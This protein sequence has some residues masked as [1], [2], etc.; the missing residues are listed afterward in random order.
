LH[1]GIGRNISVL[2]TE[3]LLQRLDEIGETLGRKG[4]ALLL[5][6]VGSV[7]VELERMDEYSDLDFFVIVE[8]GQ[9]D[10]YI[11]RLDWLEETYPLAYAFKNSDVGCKILFEDGIYGEYAIFEERELTDA[12]YTEGRVVWK[13]PLYSNTA[14]AKPR[15]ALPSQKCDALDFPLNEALT[16]LYVGLGRYARGERLSAA[17]FIQGHAIDRILSV[18]HLLEPEVVYYPDPFGNE[19]RLEK[20]YPGFAEK[21]GGMLQGYDR[22]P[23]SALC[24]LEFIE[25]V[26]PANPRLSTEI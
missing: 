24:I 1:S 17:R 2:R 6:G 23:E 7:G 18:L 4:G 25:A 5:L 13:D 8:A 20:R 14:I 22:V 15:R 21:L 9:K 16:N 3:L 11:D 10:R 12:A 19:R 26:Y